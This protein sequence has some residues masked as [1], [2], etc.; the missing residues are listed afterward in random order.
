MHNNQSKRL[1]FIPSA[2][3]DE[4]YAKER[5]SETVLL[6]ILIPVL[7]SLLGVSLAACVVLSLSSRFSSAPTLLEALE[8]AAA[9]R[10]KTI[11]QVQSLL[12]NTCIW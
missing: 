5:T 6:K 11:I 1:F 12:V 3:G 8:S 4:S 7:T 2:V 9:F 10:K